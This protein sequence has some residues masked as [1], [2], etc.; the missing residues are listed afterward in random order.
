V[1][2]D[3]GQRAL[4]WLIDFVLILV[5]LIPLYI[6]GYA[7][8]YFFT[9]LGYLAALVIGILLAVQVGQTGQSPGMRTIGLKCINQNTGQP[10]GPGLGFVR[11]IAH[12]I[13]SVICYIGWLF[14]LWD[15]N[16]QTLADK[17]MS[18]VVV[19]VPA[20]PFSLTPPA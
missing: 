9:V 8:S 5:V 11:S 1:L 16:R 3:W 13:D 17:V 20:Q 2:A 18:T 19:K 7:V 10:I 15:K 4:G 14:P 12:A 6:L